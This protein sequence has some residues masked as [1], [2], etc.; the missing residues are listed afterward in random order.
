MPA[1]PEARALH[2]S[3]PAT[4]A[5]LASIGPLLDV[6]LG[7]GFWDLDLAASGSH[8][9]AVEGERVVGFVSAVLGASEAEVPGL[10]SPVCTVRIA[11][12]C[13]EARDRGIATQLV[14]E[15]CEECER[16]GAAGLLAY[17]WVHAPTGRAPLAGTLRR[18]GFACERRIDGFYASEMAPACPACHRSPCVCPAD[19]YW[20]PAGLAD[21]GTTRPF[22]RPSTRPGGLTQTLEVAMADK[23][24]AEKARIKPGT[25]FAV[26]N[27]APGVVESLG[28]PEGSALVDAAEADL[29]FLFVNTRA[30]LE[31]LM[32]PAV[33]GLAETAAI[34]VFYRKGSKAA[35]LDM[36]R[37]S[38]WAI[39]EGLAMR[40]LGLV[41]IDD[42]WSAFRLRPAGP[43]GGRETGGGHDE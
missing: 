10:P 13:P 36:S 12:V 40:P 21:Q 30:E 14:R 37:D 25:T 19:V 33:A 27:G 22:A 4:T 43:S 6:S 32:P 39:A 17:A 41:S 3:R 31:A 28:L 8:R 24:V 38:V 18:L 9:V 1:M 26:I 11:A 23:T 7:V 42:T 34:W 16:L 20:R 35:G 5:D 2:D 15:A 29:V